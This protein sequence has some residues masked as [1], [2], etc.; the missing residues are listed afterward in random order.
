MGEVIQ[1]RDY[2]SKRAIERAHK[3]LE[4]HMMEIAQIAFPNVLEAHY[5][6]SSAPL[7]EPA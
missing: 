7:N 3:E 2:M 6:D 1:I 5:H 4:K